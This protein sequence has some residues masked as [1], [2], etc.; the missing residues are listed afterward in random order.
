MVANCA[1]MLVKVAK[2]RDNLL[3]DKKELIEFIHATVEQLK[4]CR[5]YI[6]DELETIDSVGDWLFD[7]QE[8][9]EEEIKKYKEEK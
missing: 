9:M 3:E 2:E 6:E 5:Y 1:N 7:I 8:V 4:T